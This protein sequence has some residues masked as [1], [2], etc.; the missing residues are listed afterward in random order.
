MITLIFCFSYRLVP[1]VIQER[2]KALNE[3]T[4]FILD[5]SSRKIRWYMDILALLLHQI[6]ESQ[7][8]FKTCIIIINHNWCRNLGSYFSQ[9]FQG[10]KKK[11]SLYLAQ[12]FDHV[13]ELVL[14]F[15][16]LDIL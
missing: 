10:Q 12:G 1:M 4:H 14:D 2:K 8:S 13:R 11:L 15:N 7:P 5:R 9:T 3:S 6:F 16:D